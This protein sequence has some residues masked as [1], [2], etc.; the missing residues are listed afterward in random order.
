M[1]RMCN[2]VIVVMYLIESNMQDVKS[3][4]SKVKDE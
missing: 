3:K 4:C 1:M 2:D